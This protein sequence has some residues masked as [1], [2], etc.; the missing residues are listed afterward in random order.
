MAKAI[1]KITVSLMCFVKLILL[2]TSLLSRHWAEGTGN[3]FG[4]LKYCA[5]NVTSCQIVTDKL[6]TVEGMINTCLFYNYEGCR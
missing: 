5:D 2:M 1:M 4:L 3:H 6:H